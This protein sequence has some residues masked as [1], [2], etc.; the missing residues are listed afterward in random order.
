MD[1]AR[2]VVRIGHSEHEIFMPRSTKG[3]V[4]GSDSS[5]AG[6]CGGSRC[7]WLPEILAVEPSKQ[8]A[9]FPKNHPEQ[10]TS[11]QDNRVPTPWELTNI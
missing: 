8:G 6:G 3:T 4:L 7:V 5:T 10:K 2:A 9:P 1:E 11:T